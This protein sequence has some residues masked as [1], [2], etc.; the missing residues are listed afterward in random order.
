MT[1][2]QQNALNAAQIQHD[3]VRRN[4]TTALLQSS[5]SNQALIGVITTSDTAR[6]AAGE[7]IEWTDEAKLESGMIPGTSGTTKKLTKIV[8]APIAPPAHNG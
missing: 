7:T 8:P 2:Q 4:L 3:V 5:L 1:P 6:T